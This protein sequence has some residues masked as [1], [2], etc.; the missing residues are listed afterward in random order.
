MGPTG[1]VVAVAGL[2][3]AVAGLLLDFATS[4][5]LLLDFATLL[6]FAAVGPWLVMICTSSIG[7]SSAE[8]YTNSAIPRGTTLDERDMH[9]ILDMET[10]TSSVSVMTFFAC[11]AWSPLPS[12][13][14]DIRSS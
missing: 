12:D 9:N 11:F 1:L 8:M 13:V 4:L 3:V 14:D 10:L 7:T 6:D 2:V 5:G